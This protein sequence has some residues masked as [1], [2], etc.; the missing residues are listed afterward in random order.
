M[1]A[2]LLVVRILYSSLR[3]QTAL[4]ISIAFFSEKQLIGGD[5]AAMFK[6]YRQALLESP[7]TKPDE[8]F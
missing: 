5:S 6:A 1:H 7:L 2:R 8:R 4:I 3:I